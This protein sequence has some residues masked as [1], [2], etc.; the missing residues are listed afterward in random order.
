MLRYITSASDEICLIAPHAKCKGIY[1]MLLSVQKNLHDDDF[2]MI[3][4]FLRVIGF[5]SL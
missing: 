4:S 5:D 3:D 1:S 2:V